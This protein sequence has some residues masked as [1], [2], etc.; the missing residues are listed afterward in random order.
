VTEPLEDASQPGVKKARLDSATGLV[1]GVCALDGEFPQD[2]GNNTIA[3]GIICIRPGDLSTH[4]V[5]PRNNPVAAGTS[6]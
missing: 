4:L 6:L 2:A 3:G 1:A 5:K